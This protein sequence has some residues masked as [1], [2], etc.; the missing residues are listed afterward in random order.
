[1]D[2]DQG[3][4][5]GAPRDPCGRQGQADV[6]TISSPGWLGPERG[7]SIARLAA[8]LSCLSLAAL[9]LGAL[10]GEGAIVSGLKLVSASLTVG[11]VPG[12]LCLLASGLATQLSLLETAALGIAVSLAIVQAVTMVILLLHVPVAGA[13]VALTAGCVGG[14]LLVMWRARHGPGGVPV[15]REEVA[16]G[17]LILLLSALLYV[18]G[19][20]VMSG[21]D[22]IHAGVIR[23]LGLLPRPALDNFYV[24]PGIVYTYPFPGAHVLVAMIGRLAD[25]DALFVY[26]KLRFFWGPA[27]LLFVYAAARVVLRRRDLAVVSG[28]TAWLLVAVG[29]FSEVPK[30]LW[31]QL[32]PYSHVSD[33]AMSV[34]LPA[35][36]VVLF[37]FVS[38]AGRRA[39]L[40]FG[41][42]TLALIVTVTMVHIREIVQVVVYLAAFMAAVVLLRLNGDLLARAA[43]LLVVSVGV[44]G[45]YAALHRRLVEPTGL[46]VPLERL[47]QLAAGMSF[48]DRVVS[49][50]RDSFF[51]QGFGLLFS[52]PNAVL[53]LLCP[54]VLIAVRTGALTIFFASS[55]A[56][57]T[58]IIRFPGLTIPYLQL[59]YGEMFF[60]PVRNIIFFLYVLAG[61]LLYLAANAI[62]R[63]RSRW[64]AVA[65]LALVCVVLWRAWKYGGRVLERYQGSFLLCA[66]LLCV[67]AL[68]A[69]RSGAVQRLADRLLPAAPRSGWGAVWLVLLAVTAVRLAAPA[70]SPFVL[71][72]H[73]LLTPEA[74]LRDFPCIP[75]SPPGAPAV[76]E[77]GSCP[78]SP[79]LIRWAEGHLPISAVMAS[80]TLNRYSPTTFMPQRIVAW[81]TVDASAS[82][83][84]REIYPAYYRFL[85]ASMAAYGAQPLF[86]ARES[87]AEKER[88]LT[89]VKATHVLVDPMVYAEMKRVLAV[90]P[91]TFRLMF[92]DGRWAV[93]E[94]QGTS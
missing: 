65:T 12:L 20:P 46:A 37:H 92:D 61:P 28:G 90:W 1:V 27:A 47:G 23:R 49:P 33:V 87:L 68:A 7:L 63:I 51:S 17:G 75:Q 34:F 41:C 76:A 29:A 91:E 42:G 44:V 11:L 14:G 15:G 80:N 89:A 82:L 81:P 59:T 39:F 16:L 53:L 84:G 85:D 43:G 9:V 48:W 26:R 2:G 35:L 57:Y 3:V 22:R 5:G 50:L 62:A 4:D 40:F 71:P 55:I 36:L 56:A 58:L 32:A 54:L 74:V 24:A 64:A 86:N 78:P 31:A 60:V 45:G 73:M 66:I 30:Y 25:L 38:S 13:A 8:A 83:Y 18:R 10:P 6:G 70:A 79:E 67:V 52:G 88:F 21:E 93:Y 77:P 94:V 72:P 19:S 69:H